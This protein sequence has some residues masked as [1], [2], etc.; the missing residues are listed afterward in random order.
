MT[1]A[2]TRRPFLKTLFSWRVIPG[3]ILGIISG[4]FVI[5]QVTMEDV[6]HLESCDYYQVGVNETVKLDNGCTVAGDIELIVNGQAVK[7]YDREGITTGLVIHC[8]T[9]CTFKAP[10]GASVSRRNPEEVGNEMLT[11]GCGITDGCDSVL[12]YT[13]LDLITAKISTDFYSSEELKKNTY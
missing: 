10:W 11:N 8:S 1:Q 7:M 13:R 3:T 5:H 6:T 2:T 4:V 9:G 12:V